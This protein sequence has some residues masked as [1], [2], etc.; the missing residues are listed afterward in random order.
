MLT[1]PAPMLRLSRY[2]PLGS[3]SRAAMAVLMAVLLLTGLDGA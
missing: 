1:R 2:R 3:N